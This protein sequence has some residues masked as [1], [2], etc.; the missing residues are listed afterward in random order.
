MQII[1]A[2]SDQRG[3][4]FLAGH[5]QVF[6]K[7]NCIGNSPAQN[8]HT[9]RAIYDITISALYLHGYTLHDIFQAIMS[10]KSIDSRFLN[11]YK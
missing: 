8:N 9:E 7:K 4:A 5:S 3:L 6:F 10:Y 11:N 1:K 2:Q